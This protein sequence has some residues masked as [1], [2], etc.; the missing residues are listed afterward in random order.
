MSAVPIPAYAPHQ[1]T[2]PLLVLLFLGLSL[3]AVATMRV[4]RQPEYLTADDWRD[5]TTMLSICAAI[6]VTAGSVKSSAGT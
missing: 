1:Y 4:D 2:R 5:N 3:S 6:V